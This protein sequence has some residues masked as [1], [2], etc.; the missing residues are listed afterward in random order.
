MQLQQITHWVSAYNRPLPVLN[1]FTT[2]NHLPISCDDANVRNSNAIHIDNLSKPITRT[3]HRK[4][5][6]VY[7]GKDKDKVVTL[8]AWIGLIGLQEFELSE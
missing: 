1:V 7:K 5:V 6:N 4:V 2:Y 8:Q 3:L